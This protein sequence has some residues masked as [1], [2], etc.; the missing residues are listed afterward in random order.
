MG[1]Y[2][3]TKKERLCNKRTISALYAGAHRFMAFPLSVHWMAVDHS[4]TASP[5]Q[6]VIVAPKKK[7]RHAVDRNRAKRMMRE[8]YRMRKQK[9]AETLAHHDRAVAVGINYVHHTIIPFQQ[10]SKQFDKVFDT[11]SR[12]LEEWISDEKN[13]PAANQTADATAE[14]PQK[15][16][17]QKA[18]PVTPAP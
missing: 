9:I 3:F 12:Q 11:L 13:Q 6:V 15:E 18:T 4:R 7:L 5:L 1:N 8:C 2:T 16:A 10:M 14:P 17:S